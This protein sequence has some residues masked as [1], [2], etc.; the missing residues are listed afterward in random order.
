MTA[1][2][3]PEAALPHVVVLATGGTVAGTA[4]P[5]SQAGYNAGRVS[6]QQ[7]L[8]AVPGIESR[9]RLSAEQVSA[10]GSQDISESVWL[11]LGRRIIALAERGDVDGVVIT[12]GTDT[13]EETALFLHLVVPHE[14][15]VVLVGSMR[16]STAHSADGPLNLLEAV[17]V[18][19]APSA[20]GR[21]AM[22]VLNDT[23][24]GAF[25]VTKTSTTEVQTFRSPNLGPL[26][27]VGVTGVSFFRPP[28]GRRVLGLPPAPLP[29]VYVVPAHAGMDAALVEAACAAGARGLV[30][31]GVGNGNAAQV[32]IEAL[33][34][35]AAAGVAVVRSSRTGSG[36][37]L[38][39]I[40]VDDDRFGFVASQLHNPAKAR[41]LLQLLLAHGVSGVDALQQAF[42][43]V[44]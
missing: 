31:A 18:A 13:M 17:M 21:G 1:S 40:E 20:R 2:D 11:D 37:V 42:D 32:A 33:A 39:N 8:A 5:R 34:K 7:L 15:P 12:H 6:P 22:V 16:P 27:H 10:I 9:A 35:A 24:H 30:L 36:P 41:V 23:I 26:G 44:M 19:A 38:R 25:D 14:L 3:V 43:Q 29:K 4:D 28:H